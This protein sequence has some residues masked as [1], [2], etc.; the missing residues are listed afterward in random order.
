MMFLFILLVT[1]LSIY[2]WGIVAGLAVSYAGY[3]Y[4]VITLLSLR[5]KYRTAHIAS[6]SPE[7][8]VILRKWG[9]CFDMP[10][11]GK[12][13]AAMAN[14]FGVLS[15][16]L[17]IAAGVLLTPWF[18][19]VILVSFVLTSVLI[20]RY[21]ATIAVSTGTIPEVY[22]LEVLKALNIHV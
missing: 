13:H 5:I 2:W 11:G 9:H 12:I 16:V 4:L 15:C 17:S 6:L 22:Y 7:A 1:V 21:D 20:N 14:T 18:F 8:N 10:H 19:I 3:G